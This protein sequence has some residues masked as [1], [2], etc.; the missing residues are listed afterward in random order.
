MKIDYQQ[1]NSRNF[2]NLS[3]NDF[4][5]HQQV[6][7][8]WRNVEDEWKLVPISF[9]EDWSLE[10]CRK[11]ASDV[12]VHM[13]KDQTAFGAFDGEKLVGFIIRSTGNAR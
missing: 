3:L 6:T 12:L 1:L 2:T 5:R 10:Q 7:E 4:V 13:G 11:I 9:V 8:C